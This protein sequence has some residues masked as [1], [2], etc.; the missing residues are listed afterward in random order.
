[1]GDKATLQHARGYLRTYKRILIEINESIFIKLL[2]SILSLHRAGT[3][4]NR[5]RIRITVIFF[6]FIIFLLIRS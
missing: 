3:T 1:M 4:V 5:V 2:V 6:V